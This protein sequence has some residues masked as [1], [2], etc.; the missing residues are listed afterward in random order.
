MDSNDR[1]LHSDL[2]LARPSSEKL[3]LAED[4]NEH[5]DPQVDNVQKVRGCR[6]LS[7]KHDLFIKSL[8]TG[9]RGSREREGR[10]IVTDG[11]METESSGYSRIDTHELSDTKA[12]CPRLAQ[13]P[14]S[15]DTSPGGRGHGNRV[16]PLMKKL[17]ALIPIGKAG[18]HLLQWSSLGISTILQGRPHGQ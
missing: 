1:L 6:A 17:C 16:L 4:W 14:T 15:W 8:P 12:A 18:V 13:F 2:C 3:F 9:H 5:R 7:P 11:S 10:K